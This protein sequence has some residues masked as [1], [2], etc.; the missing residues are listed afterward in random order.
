MWI[1]FFREPLLSEKIRY[2]GKREFCAQSAHKTL[3]CSRRSPSFKKRQLFESLSSG[4][5]HGSV[6][7]RGFNN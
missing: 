2:D 4:A 5:E 1:Y 6:P 7:L 3:R